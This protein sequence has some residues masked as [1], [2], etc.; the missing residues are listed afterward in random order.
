VPVP[1]LAAVPESVVVA[2]LDKEGE[3]D[4]VPVP[5]PVLAAVLL[6]V[7][8]VVAAPVPVPDTDVVPELEGVCVPVL[9]WLAVLLGV[10]GGE[11]DHVPV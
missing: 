8:V 11:G 2:V 10:P 9:V 3:M 1:V 7:C 5:D 6:A 4:D